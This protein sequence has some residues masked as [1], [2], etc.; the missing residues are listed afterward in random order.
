MIVIKHNKLTTNEQIYSADFY[1]ETIPNSLWP[2]GVVDL[3]KS[4][5]ARTGLYT[6]QKTAEMI[7]ELR[8]LNADS[9]DVQ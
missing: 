9:D 5:T 2:K 4:R 8:R 1:Y 3:I 7:R 6:R